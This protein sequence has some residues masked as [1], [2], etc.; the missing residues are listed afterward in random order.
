MNY[1]F[2]IY[3]H[4]HREP[5][6][7]PRDHIVKFEEASHA[8]AWLER[9]ERN[10][11]P[12][13]TV[14]SEQMAAIRA[15]ALTDFQLDDQHIAW[16][17]RFKNGTWDEVPPRHDEP[18]PGVMPSAPRS[19]RPARAQRPDGHVTITELC[20]GSGVAPSDARAILRASGRAKPEY[21][22]AFAPNE[23]AAIKKLC[24]IKP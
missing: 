7:H 11:P 3:A 19:Q 5:D 13:Y 10:L 23:V 14:R 12:G 21:G 18:I 1:P 9:M 8:R 4:G 15:A 2:V 20:A 16:I 6:V 17:N 24:G 22:W